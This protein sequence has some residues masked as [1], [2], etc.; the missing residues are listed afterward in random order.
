MLHLCKKRKIN[1][2]T[3]NFVL[4]NEEEDSAR[5]EQHSKKRIDHAEPS[6]IVVATLVSP[7]TS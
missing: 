3:T 6:T 7:V 2:G 5:L 4:S 1:A